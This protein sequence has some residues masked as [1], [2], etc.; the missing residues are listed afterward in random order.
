MPVPPIRDGSNS[1][2]SQSFTSSLNHLEHGGD[3]SVVPP[4]FRCVLQ[5]VLSFSPSHLPTPHFPHATP[6]PTRPQPS[7]ATGV[8][9]A[10]D[11]DPTKTEPPCVILTMTPGG[12]SQVSLLMQFEYSFPPDPH[13]P[14]APPILSRTHLRLPHDAGIYHLPLDLPSYLAKQ[15]S[16]LMHG[17]YSAHCVDLILISDNRF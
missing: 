4:A 6:I 10:S 2:I 16:L 17:D 14:H 15:G 13:Y 3:E 1:S 9:L 8:F 5:F 7:P 12:S 11:R